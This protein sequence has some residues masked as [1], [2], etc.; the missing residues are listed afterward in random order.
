MQQ[1]FNGGITFNPRGSLKLPPSAPKI[2]KSPC[3][4]SKEGTKL[5]SE[6]FQGYMQVE[7]LKAI[8]L[9]GAKHLILWIVIQFTGCREINKLLKHE[10]FKLENCSEIFPVLRKRKWVAKLDLKHTYFHLG[11]EEDWTKFVY[12]RESFFRGQVDSYQTACF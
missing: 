1:S 8:H 9:S 4:R 2:S 6:T 10:T 7:A 5:A 11:W 12:F 3:L